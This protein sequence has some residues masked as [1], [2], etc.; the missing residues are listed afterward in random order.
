MQTDPLMDQKIRVNTSTGHPLESEDFL[1]ELENIL[2]RKIL[3]GKAGRPI[4]QKEI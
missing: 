1:S 3:P 4:K 2:C